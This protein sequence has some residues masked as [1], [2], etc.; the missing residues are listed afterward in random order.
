MKMT[1]THYKNN[2]LSIQPKRNRIEQRY[3][4][5]P[6]T[7]KSSKKILQ[8]GIA[9]GV[10]LSGLLIRVGSTSVTYGEIVELE[11]RLEF[12]GILKICRIPAKVTHIGKDSLTINFY[13][14]NSETFSYLK[15]LMFNTNLRVYGETIPAGDWAA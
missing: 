15:K 2:V 4:N 14:F 7:L 3:L 8:A 11:F 1:Q 10:S 6:V 9:F 5:L 12:D 13:Q